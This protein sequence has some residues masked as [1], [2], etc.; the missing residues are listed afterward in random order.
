MKKILLMVLMVVVMM[1]FVSCATMMETD[2]DPEKA[3]VVKIIDSP[4]IKKD[5]LFVLANSWAVDTFVSAE[6]V[7]E[8]SDK[9]AGIIKGKYVLSFSEGIYTY[10]ARSTITIEVKDG[11]VRITIA[12]PYIRVTSDLL[13]GEY[14]KGVGYRQLKS[15]TSFEKNILPR[16][17]DLIESFKKAIQEPNEVF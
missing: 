11:A 17:L 8:Y 4:G 7:I 14:Y 5:R 1:M 2:L 9:E 12:D 13:N 6:S 16:Y 10:T 15:M 3:Q